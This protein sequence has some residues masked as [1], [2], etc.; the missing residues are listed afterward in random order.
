MDDALGV[1]GV[2]GALPIGMNGTQTIGGNM[3][4]PDCFDLQSWAIK[5]HAQFYEA[6]HLLRPDN[7]Y[8]AMRTY[9]EKLGKPKIDTE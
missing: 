9:W 7:Q 6:V 2:H 8:K 1:T 5:H 4:E 3:W